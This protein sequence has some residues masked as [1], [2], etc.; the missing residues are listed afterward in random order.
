MSRQGQKIALKTAKDRPEHKSRQEAER[1]NFSY[2]DKA[3][4]E[5]EELKNKYTDYILDFSPDSVINIEKL[6]F[7]I[8]DGKKYKIHSV[9]GLTI[10]RMEE[11]LAV[12]IGQVY[13]HNT[14]FKWIVEEDPFG[15][16]KYYLAVISENGFMTI[17]CTRITDHYKMTGNKTRKALYREFKKNES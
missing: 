11:I 6:Y 17:E 15:K 10:K 3:L 5:I 8:L 7:D 1:F 14:D 9:F 4:S 13:V 16:N 2:R 12:Y